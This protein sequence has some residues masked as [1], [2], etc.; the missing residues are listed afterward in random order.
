[1]QQERQLSWP[2]CTAK[3]NRS[4]DFRGLSRTSCRR[5]KTDNRI[6][7]EPVRYFEDVATLQAREELQQ[8]TTF[9]QEA[10]EEESHQ[11]NSVFALQR[12]VKQLTYEM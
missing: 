5:Y 1:M 4:R 11:Q 12:D 8:V 10:R 6:A 9:L 7:V 2:S 3:G